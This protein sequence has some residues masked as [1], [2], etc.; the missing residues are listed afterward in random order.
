MNFSILIK[1]LIDLGMSLIPLLG[2]IAF[3]VFIFGV[4]RYIRA[5]GDEKD[6][7]SKKNFLIWGVVGLFVIFSIW[8]IITYIKGEFGFG[9]EVGIPQLPGGG[10][11]DTNIIWGDQV[12]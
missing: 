9:G 7:Q 5:T 4:A 6:I 12:K 8:G 11:S 1:K 10:V 2:V 3:L